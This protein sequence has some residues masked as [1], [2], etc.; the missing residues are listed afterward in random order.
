MSERKWTTSGERLDSVLAPVI[1]PNI[2][3][4]K[5][6]AISWQM[7]NNRLEIARDEVNKNK[8]MQS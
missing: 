7:L 4:D 2:T 8:A 6:T 1:R 5:K 3:V